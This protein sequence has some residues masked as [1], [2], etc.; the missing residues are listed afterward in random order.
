MQRILLTILLYSFLNLWI[1]GVA[2][3]QDIS[4]IPTE[5]KEVVDLQEDVDNNNAPSEKI[6][7]DLYQSGNNI[8][9]EEEVVD[10]SYL[11]G[12]K[13]SVL[14]KI[15]GN[16]FAIANNIET[17]GEIGQSFFGIASTI[18]IKEQ[19]KGDLFI[20]GRSVKISAEIK[21]NVYILAEEVFVDAQIGDDVNITAS[22]VIVNK[23]TKEDLKIN[24]DEVYINSDRV[25]GGLEISAYKLFITDK[26]K[27]DGDFI[28][29]GKQVE[30]IKDYKDYDLIDY[31]STGIP[32]N[33]D[34][35]PSLNQ[36][37]YLGI[38][39]MKNIGYASYGVISLL[40]I[41]GDILA[42]LVIFKVFPIKSNKVV[43]NLSINSSQFKSNILNG[44]LL[45]VFTIV[46]LVITLVSVVGIPL[47]YLLLLLFLVV[48]Q[49][50]K[51]YGIYKLGSLLVERVQPKASR[52]FV[53]IFVGEL[54]LIII[55]LIFALIPFIGDSLVAIFLIIF[56]LWTAGAVVSNKFDTIRRIYLKH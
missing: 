4:P 35:L 34:N 27:I 54:S 3:A 42:A 17:G 40:L 49:I 1:P 51:Y 31:R 33:F 36:L 48:L 10:N 6:I 13:I 41:I 30:D 23:N 32:K 53:N 45:I 29:N 16:L 21:G 19:I 47:F 5:N 50:S 26:I 39:K 37:P 18:E 56:T 46:S 14:K 8:V 20:V 7:N 9:I 2:V 52:L 28:V 22:R 44:L 11:A 55:V 15:G 25:Y 12:I 43:E 38:E 24:A